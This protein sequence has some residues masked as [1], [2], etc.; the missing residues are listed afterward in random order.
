MLFCSKDAQL[1]A[2]GIA[3]MDAEEAAK[4]ATGL[5]VTNALEVFGTETTHMRNN[6]NII[7][8]LGCFVGRSEKMTKM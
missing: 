5:L 8:Y 1:L 2:S 6:N 3:R 4:E 7:N